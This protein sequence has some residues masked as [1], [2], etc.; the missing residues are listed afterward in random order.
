MFIK[1]CSF[2]EGAGG[3]NTNTNNSIR[4]RKEE[5]EGTNTTINNSLRRRKASELRA[6]LPPERRAVSEDPNNRRRKASELREEFSR[7][8]S[9]AQEKNRRRKASDLREEFARRAERE[10]KHHQQQHQHQHQQQYQQQQHHPHP[11]QH[12]HQHHYQ[13]ENKQEQ[14]GREGQEVPKINLP[15]VCYYQVLDLEDTATEKEIR[16]AFLEK[17]VEYLH[18]GFICIVIFSKKKVRICHPDRHTEADVLH[19]NKMETKMK[20]VSFQPIYENVDLTCLSQGD[21]CLFYSLWQ[22]ETSRVR[23]GSKN[24]ELDWSFAVHQELFKSEL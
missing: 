5:K 12:Q 20:E 19:Q 6:E 21:L 18:I 23:Q 9:E 22:S 10:Q 4:R 11:H 2:K 17:V 15:L 16:K 24:W 8:V 7:Q 1:P 3:A 13:Q 14:R